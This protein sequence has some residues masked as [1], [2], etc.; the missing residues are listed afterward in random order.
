METGTHSTPTSTEHDERRQDQLL[1]DI[2]ASSNTRRLGRLAAIDSINRNL[3]TEDA[4]FRRQLEIDMSS[5]TLSDYS[6]SPGD[7]DVDLG[8]DDEEEPMRIMAANTGDINVY[9]RERDEP[10]LPQPQRRD[11]QHRRAVGPER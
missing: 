1:R 7:G 5:D 9:R 2:E 11:D 6:D 8:G 3:N 4:A 10:Q